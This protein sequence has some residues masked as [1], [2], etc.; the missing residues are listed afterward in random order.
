VSSRVRTDNYRSCVYEQGRERKE[1]FRARNRTEAKAKHK[2]RRVNVR[3]GQ[4]PDKS[5]ATVAD[6]A[7][8]FLSMIDGLGPED[9]VF[10]T[11]NGLPLMHRNVSR[12]FATA[13][14][15]AA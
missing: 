12:D 7:T 10:T 4:E 6:V 1:Y 11:A 15:R 3:K 13:G 14:D 5:T 2:D 9:F 8:D